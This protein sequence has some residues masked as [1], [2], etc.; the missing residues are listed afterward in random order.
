MNRPSK[1]F[2]RNEALFIPV[3]PKDAALISVKL[4]FFADGSLEVKVD[5][6]FTVWPDP[7]NDPVLT[8]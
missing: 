1:V 4:D 3:R 6:D 2:W 5:E 8:N 7:R